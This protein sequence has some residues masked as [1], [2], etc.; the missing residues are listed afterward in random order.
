MFTDQEIANEEWRPIPGFEGLYEVSNLGR[1]KSLPRMRRGRGVGLHRAGGRILSCNGLAGA[2][3]PIVQLS[4]IKLSQRFVHR[5]VADAFIPNTNGYE[6]V[7]HKDGDKT[8]NRSDNLEW[9]TF[10]QNVAHAWKTGL[11]KDGIHPN[12]KRVRVF[13]PNGEIKEFGSISDASRTIGADQSNISRLCS[14]HR[15][16][17]K[18]FKAEFIV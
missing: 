17:V 8:N 13:Y 16:I 4:N 11:R 2:G 18:G 10:S 15:K 9:C 12:K 7:N 5:L 1:V 3:Y 6:Y 14:G